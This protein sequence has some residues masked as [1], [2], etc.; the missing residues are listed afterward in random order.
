MTLISQAGCTSTFFSLAFTHF[1]SEISS[2]WPPYF[3]SKRY[4]RELSSHG[5]TAK[6]VVELREKVS[7]G[8]TELQQA[9]TARDSLAE[10][11]RAEGETTRVK[12]DSL[13]QEFQ[14]SKE[15]VNET[16][17]IVSLFLFTSSFSLSMKS[18]SY[19]VWQFISKSY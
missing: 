15:Q 2:I 19:L 6:T 10:Q 13:N 3:I 11:L 4:E 5:E 8:S 18:V 12:F 7:Q 14:L 16:A 1:P 9:Q 17:F